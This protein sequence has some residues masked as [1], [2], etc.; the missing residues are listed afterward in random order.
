MWKNGDNNFIYFTAYYENIKI[1][2]VSKQDTSNI[3]LNQFLL[4]T[5]RKAAML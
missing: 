3:Y 4:I 2:L 5:F 1:S